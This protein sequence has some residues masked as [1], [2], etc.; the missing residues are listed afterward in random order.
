[1][2]ND[3][4]KEILS[5]M[6]ENGKDTSGLT[7]LFNYV[8]TMENHL[9][10]AYGEV[11]A[12]QRELS[13][14][15]EE[16]SHP[17]RTLLQSLEA[18][19]NE[20]SRNLNQL[21]AKIVD[22]CKDAVSMFKQKGISALNNMAHFFRV[23][24]ALE[25]LQDNMKTLIKNDLSSVAKI[26]TISAESHAA[27]RHLKNIVRA[28]RGKEPIQDVKPNGKITSLLTRPYRSEIKSAVNALGNIQKAITKLDHLDRASSLKESSTNAVMSTESAGEAAAPRESVNKAEVP[29]KSVGKPVVLKE[30]TDV[31]M[32]ARQ[33]ADRTVGLKESASFERAGLRCRLN[34]CQRPK[35]DAKTARKPQKQHIH[36]A[37]AG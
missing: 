18:N 7:A 31:T 24:P 8:V 36:P 11:Q 9:N 17:I 12:M 16:R 23:K 2:K 13:G 25:A 1:M 26:E 28:Y 27:S 6:A 29:A 30:S 5:I 35:L 37:G 22:G 21:K 15:R 19:L 20:A 10:K 4:I 33:T 34:A 14:L 32:S 3:H